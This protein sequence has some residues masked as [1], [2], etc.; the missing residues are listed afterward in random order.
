MQSY[1][2]NRIKSRK[3]Y[4]LTE[5]ARLLS[6]D[7]KTC[8]RWVKDEGLKVIEKNVSPLVMG[9]DLI[10]FIKNKREKRKV[11]VKEN[12]FFCLKCHKA[13][14]AKTGSEQTIKT[15]K[16]IGKDNHEQLKK[17]GVC[18][19]CGTKLNKYLGV[20]QKD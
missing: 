19:L 1:C 16:R 4:N 18:E 10:D 8:S 7:R 2:F 12:Q 3:S 11:P 13:V 6:I 20:S 9:A 17:I 15:G 5:I 14:I